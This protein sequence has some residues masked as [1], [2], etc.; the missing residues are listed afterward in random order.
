MKLAV[1]I[2]LGAL[3]LAPFVIFTYYSMNLAIYLPMEEK[4]IKEVSLYDEKEMYTEKY[5]EKKELEYKKVRIN[6]MQAKETEVVLGKEK[7]DPYI[8][9]ITKEHLNQYIRWTTEAIENINKT[10]EFE[11]KNWEELRIV[12]CNCKFMSKEN[13]STLGYYLPHYNEVVIALERYPV[14][15]ERF[16]STVSHEVGHYIYI[17]KLSYRFKKKY[18]KKYINDKKLTFDEK[19]E[20]TN[21]YRLKPKNEKAWENMIEEQIVEDIRTTLVGEKKNRLTKKVVSP[22]AK[23]ELVEEI[24]KKRDNNKTFRN[25]TWEKK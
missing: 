23:K 21:L 6:Y 12:L 10:F 2:M 20:L 8:S 4:N 19:M 17:N 3:I 24:R 25:M 15:E 9:K 1:K 7:T 22:D 16:K 14:E 5:L 11:E 18:Y 13:K